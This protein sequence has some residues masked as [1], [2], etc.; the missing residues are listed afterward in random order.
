MYMSMAA[1]SRAGRARRFWPFSVFALFS[2]PFRI[3]LVAAFAMSTGA[4]FAQAAGGVGGGTLT[5]A[6]TMRAVQ[7]AQA[8]Q[9]QLAPAVVTGL[10]ITVVAA[11]ALVRLAVP[12]ET[13]KTVQPAALAGLLA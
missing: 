8:T 7:A 5:A 3:A 6:A 1:S 4:A 10:V 11:A 9:Q 12:A 2:L 13:A